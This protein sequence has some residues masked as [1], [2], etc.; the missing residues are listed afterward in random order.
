[1]QNSSAFSS[2]FVPFAPIQFF[3]HQNTTTTHTHILY[4]YYITEKGEKEREREKLS[5]KLFAAFPSHH[6]KTSSTKQ[7]RD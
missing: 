7:K 4:Y 3:F 5:E 6:R 1:M 2:A